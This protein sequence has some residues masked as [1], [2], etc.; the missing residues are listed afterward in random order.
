MPAAQFQWSGPLPDGMRTSVVTPG[1][2][3]SAGVT[4][5]KIEGRAGAA[6]KASAIKVVDPS[7]KGKGGLTGAEDSK[8]KARNNREWMLKT[9]LIRVAQEVANRHD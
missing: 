9:R 3:G 1:T 4:G 2:N 6:A 8:A 7:A 5:D